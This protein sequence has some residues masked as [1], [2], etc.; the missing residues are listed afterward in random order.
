MNKKIE[1]LINEKESGERLDIFLS[2][3]IKKFTRSYIKKIIEKKT[4]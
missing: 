2:R 4:S 3:E 1:F